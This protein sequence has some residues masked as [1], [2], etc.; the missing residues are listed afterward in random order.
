MQI[1][2][3]ANADVNAKNGDGNTALH[4]SASYGDLDNVISLLTANADVNLLNTDDGSTSL[5]YAAA[6]GHVKCSLVLTQSKVSLYVCTSS[7]TSTH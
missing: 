1:L 6:G 4:L 5:H 7:F 3:E 2:V